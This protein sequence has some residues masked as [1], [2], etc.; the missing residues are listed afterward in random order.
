MRGL[1]EGRGLE[2]LHGEAWKTQNTG[3]GLGPQHRGGRG[4][5]GLGLPV[6]SWAGHPPS[7]R[8]SVSMRSFNSISQT[9]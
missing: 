3:G 6:W 5:D 7:L 1:G 8:L 2:D 4:Q 9:E